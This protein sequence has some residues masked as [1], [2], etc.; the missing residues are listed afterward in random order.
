MGVGL[1]PALGAFCD[2]FRNLFYLLLVVVII[3]GGYCLLN[4]GLTSVLYYV[5]VGCIASFILWRIGKA[6]LR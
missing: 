2:I 4:G 5:L 1:M 3:Y 6:S